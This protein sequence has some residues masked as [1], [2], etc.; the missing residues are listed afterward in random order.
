MESERGEEMDE[1]K[2][3]TCSP[4][5]AHAVCDEWKSLTDEHTRQRA[6]TH[7]CSRPH[8]LAHTHIH[9]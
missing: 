8:F 9:T 2:V 7:A 3:L 4:S 5:C 1:Y 6:P